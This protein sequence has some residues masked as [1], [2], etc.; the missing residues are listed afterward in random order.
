MA[1]YIACTAY[2]SV[3]SIIYPRFLHA[4]QLPRILHFDIGRR[5]RTSIVYTIDFMF[6]RKCHPPC[7]YR[8]SAAYIHRIATTYHAEV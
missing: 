2:A 1:L 5:H 4:D 3:N 8:D 6:V 7:Q